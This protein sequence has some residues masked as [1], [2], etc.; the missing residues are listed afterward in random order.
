[1]Q[2]WCQANNRSVQ[3]TDATSELYARFVC[4]EE[5]LGPA[6]GRPTSFKYAAGRLLALRDLRLQQLSQGLYSEKEVTD[7]FRTCRCLLVPG[8]T[9]VPSWL[10]PP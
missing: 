1:M 7:P 6:P 2:A 8:T 4:K 5:L 9:P 10:T 3:L